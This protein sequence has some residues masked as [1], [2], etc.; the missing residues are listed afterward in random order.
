MLGGGELTVEMD[1]PP[2]P[3]HSIEMSEVWAP[4]ERAGYSIITVHRK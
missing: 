4:C 3:L 1:A 2:E